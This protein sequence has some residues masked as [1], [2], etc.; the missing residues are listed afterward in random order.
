MK[1][2]VGD[3][4]SRVGARPGYALPLSNTLRATIIA[5]AR[6]LSFRC[7]SKKGQTSAIG[8]PLGIYH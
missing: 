2:N 8:I 1:V 7:L 5:N 6:G 4:G 3:G